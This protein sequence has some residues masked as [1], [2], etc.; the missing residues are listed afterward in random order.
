VSAA[1]VACLR[2]AH[3][4]AIISSILGCLW[5]VGCSAKRQAAPS[6]S[7]EDAA[8]TRNHARIEFALAGLLKPPAEGMSPALLAAPIIVEEVSAAVRPENG[9]RR[10]V[11]AGEMA[12]V[13]QGVVYQQW[14][15][16]WEYPQGE[17]EVSNWCWLRVTLDSRGSPVIWETL[18]ARDAR[19]EIYAAQSLE[20]QAREQF[21]APVGGPAFSLAPQDASATS[22]DIVRIISDGPAPMGPMVY[23][24]AAHRIATVICRCMPAQVSAV[25]ATEYYELA[26][27]ETFPVG[28]VAPSADTAFLPARLFS[29]CAAADVLVDPRFLEQALRLP[30]G[31]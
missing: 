26:A 15:Y 25:S 28:P 2:L 20:D 13:L 21:G 29:T 7:A 8:A 23:V 30:I 27:A 5:I 10:A 11:Y 31:W 18:T 12:A 19:V 3:T 1:R 6:T 24:D 22:A 17:S 16:W 14:V 4:V 9:E